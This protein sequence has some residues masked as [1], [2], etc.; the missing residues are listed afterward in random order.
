MESF[1][2]V[3]LIVGVIFLIIYVIQENREGYVPNIVGDHHLDTIKRKYEQM[4]PKCT[5]CESRKKIEV[6]VVCNKS[7]V[8]PCKHYVKIGE[9]EQ[10]MPAPEIVY[11]LKHHRHIV[12]KHLLNYSWPK[13]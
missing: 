12:P 2:Q 4:P 8:A 1:I 7:G 13:I 6:D 9:V 5:S 3:F 10:K 11:L